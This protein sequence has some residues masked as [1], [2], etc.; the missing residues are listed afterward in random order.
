M[1][2]RKKVAGGLVGL[3]L[4]LSP[5]G[6]KAQKVI[7]KDSAL[8]KKASKVLNLDEKDVFYCPEAGGYVRPRDLRYGHMIGALIVHA[9]GGGVAVIDN[10]II[11]ELM[12]EN[13]DDE[14]EWISRRVIPKI[15]KNSDR[16]LSPEEIIEAFKKQFPGW[17]N[18]KI[19]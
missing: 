2:V 5:L 18:E 9:Y 6:S 4:T 19:Y 3:A 8:I 17:Y 1:K 14:Y 11:F 7:E 13:K 10:Q 12:F 16:I 15:D